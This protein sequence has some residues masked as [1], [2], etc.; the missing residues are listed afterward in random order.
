MSGQTILDSKISE[1]IGLRHA[2]RVRGYGE[3]AML[4]K[5][6]IQGDVVCEF[7]AFRL[8]GRHRADVDA[9]LFTAIL[10]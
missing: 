7:A 6:R 8:L 4:K 10:L 3:W 2:E 5:L 1:E 9:F